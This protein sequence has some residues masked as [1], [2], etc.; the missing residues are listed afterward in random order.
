MAEVEVTAAGAMREAAAEMVAEAAEAETDRRRR[1]RG[2]TG[3]KQRCRSTD[4]GEAATSGHWPGGNAGALTG[5]AMPA[6]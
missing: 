2:L 5:V 1:R 6:H 3:V 4:R